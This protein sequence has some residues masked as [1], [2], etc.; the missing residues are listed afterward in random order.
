MR[1]AK[2]VVILLTV[3]LIGTA[4]TTAASGQ[5]NAPQKPSNTRMADCLVRITADPA[6][7]PLNEATVAG[8]IYSSGV[9]RR[10]IVEV[11]DVE[12]ADPLQFVLVE[13]L[14]G[15]TT[16]ADA[17]QEQ[18]AEMSRLY[19]Q[20]YGKDYAQMMGMSAGTSEKRGGGA[21]SRRSM[22][23]LGGMGGG[24]MGPTTPTGPAMGG[25][26]SGGVGGGIVGGRTGG[27]M[28]PGM[29]G[30]GGSSNFSNYGSFGGAA[31]RSASSPTVEHSA[32]I[33]LT[34]D[35][36]NSVKPAAQELMDALM[37]NLRNN[38]VDTHDRYAEGL[39]RL[40]VSA[41]SQR[42][43]AEQN[44]QSAGAAPSPESTSVRERL[45]QVVDLSAL[46]S[47]T[48]LE[49]AIAVL[50][51]AVQPPLEIVALWKDL[52]EWAGASRYIPIQI[53]GMSSV[54]LGTALDLLL[55]GISDPLPG[56]PPVVYRIR[57][58]VIVIG[59]SNALGTSS[60]SAS[61]VKN[62]AD[63][64]ALAAQKDD[65]AR[66]V[67]TLE[68]NQVSMEA[69]RK[70]MYM[71]IEEAR[72]QAAKK[73]AEDT[74]TQELEKLVQLS[75]SHLE[76]LQQRVAAGQMPQAELASAQESV[77]RARIELAR[78]REELTKL[79]GGGRIEQYESELSKMAIDEAES[80]ARLDVLRRQLA[81][82][83]GQL[84]QAST[85]DPEAARIRVAQETLDIA[86]RRVGELEARIASLQPPTVT[87]IGTN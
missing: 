12:P 83:Q 25:M 19:E 52:E 33:K 9:R 48:P 74:V 80:R 45:D 28:G 31:T 65:L 38:L 10:A 84:T 77:A 87:V 16:Q 44:V 72:Q 26:S 68:L 11:L 3:A 47:E 53:D 76:L 78:R 62:Q 20:V 8:L 82:V 46:S 73:V 7:V 32:V 81:D 63:I 57:D 43:Q 29:G 36:P 54:R 40:L 24:M 64:R 56:A 69:R 23:G 75:T 86:N 71:Q 85:F 55:K 30:M 42:D 58:N 60:S 22:G 50:R 61:G 15:E 13:W 5:D 66:T 6:I 59:T 34:V 39:N 67:Q 14:S 49:E 27:G 37:V 4:A 35:L 21:T 51:N 70:A 41:K 17:A 79:T 2:C 18:D 1:T